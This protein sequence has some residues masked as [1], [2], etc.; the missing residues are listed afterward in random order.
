MRLT[1]A[2]LVSLQEEARATGSTLQDVVRAAIDARAQAP[3]RQRPVRA[4]QPEEEQ[5]VWDLA[6][7]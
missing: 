2:Q 3:L 5:H 1:D 6:Y 7:R 4:D